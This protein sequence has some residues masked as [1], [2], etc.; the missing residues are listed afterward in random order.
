MRDE[1]STPLT[2]PGSLPRLPTAKSL[3]SLHYLQTRLPDHAEWTEDPL[4]VFEAV[5]RLW[6]RAR[7]LGGSWNEA[8]TEQEE[9][10]SLVAARG[11][12]MWPVS[13]AI[14]ELLPRDN[15]ERKALLSLLGTR[16]DL[17]SRALQWAE[18]QRARVQRTFKQPSLWEEDHHG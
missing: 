2:A 15:A 17:E 7:A 5:R 13:Q 11:G 16:V 4:P 3:F 14:V 1:I 18:G 6:E 10:S 9:L 12:E 8:Q